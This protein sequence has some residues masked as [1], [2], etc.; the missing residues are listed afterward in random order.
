MIDTESTVAQSY[1]IILSCLLSFIREKDKENILHFS[2]VGTDNTRNRYDLSLYK[3]IPLLLDSALQKMNNYNTWYLVYFA[4]S[5]GYSQFSVSVSC[6]MNKFDKSRQSTFNE[7]D[8]TFIVF[9]FN[10]NNF[11]S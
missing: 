11:I 6:A 4:L 8:T 5:V 1:N 10:D 7:L 9:R 3:L 2:F